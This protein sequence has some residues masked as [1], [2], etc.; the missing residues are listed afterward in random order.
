MLGR[1]R[2]RLLVLAAGIGLLIA[3]FL[4]PDPPVPPPLAGAGF[5]LGALLSAWGAVG[6]AH[7][8]SNTVAR[9]VGRWGQRAQLEIT[10]PEIERKD[11]RFG[12]AVLP[13]DFAYINLRNRAE[14]PA[15]IASDLLGHIWITNEHGSTIY[16]RAHWA[17]C[18]TPAVNDRIVLDPGRLATLDVAWKKPASQT[19]FGLN[20]DAMANAPNWEDAQYALPPGRYRVRAKIM[21]SDARSREGQFELVN[22]GLGSLSFSW[23][24]G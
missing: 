2:D 18:P 17:K 22:P 14:H 20:S 12:D 1:L 13:S 5:G 3:A 8:A 16:L 6:I 19:A 24:E 7:S 21:A 23:K 9:F 11:F 10:G 4:A 15:G